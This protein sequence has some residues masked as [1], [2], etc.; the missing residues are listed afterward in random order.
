MSL[1]F[2]HKYVLLA[3]DFKKL[4]YSMMTICLLT[5]VKWQWAV[6]V[7]GWVTVSIR[8]QLWD[9]SSGLALGDR[10]T[11]WPCFSKKT[12]KIRDAFSTSGSF[13]EPSLASPGFNAFCLL[14]KMRS[15]R[16]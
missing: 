8:D 4:W 1:A 9:V 2:A 10:N 15:A 7:L 6:I 16:L 14:L 3:S 13:N 11:F 12:S 5:E